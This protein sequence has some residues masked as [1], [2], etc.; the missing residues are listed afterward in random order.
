[1]S[2]PR[3]QERNDDMVEYPGTRFTCP[4]K[5]V[6]CKLTL[7]FTSSLFNSISSSG[8]LLYYVDV[9]GRMLAI[10]VAAFETDAPTGTPS[11][12]PSFSPSSFPSMSSSPTVVSSE[13]PTVFT[14]SP[15]PPPTM[16][17]GMVPSISISIPP[18]TI[19]PIFLDTNAARNQGGGDDD[20]VKDK[21]P[22]ILGV[23][24]GSLLVVAMILFIVGRKRK[25]DEE[26]QEIVVIED[27][28]DDLEGDNE[29]MGDGD[30]DDD[31]SAV[32][33]EVVGGSAVYSPKK[34]KPKKK[35]QQEVSPSGGARSLAAI[36]EVP[37]V[38]DDNTVVVT[39]DEDDDGDSVKNLNDKFA[40]VVEAQTE[41]E[42]TPP[43]SPSRNGAL[44]ILGSTSPKSDYSDAEDIDGRDPLRSKSPSGSSMGSSTIYLDNDDPRTKSVTP[45]PTHL[46]S[47]KDV[48]A[49]DDEA[50]MLLM[51]QPWLDGKEDPPN[52]SR[53]RL[54]RST[55][56]GPVVAPGTH[57]MNKEKLANKDPAPKHTSGRFGTSA[58][59][60]KQPSSAF[61][62]SPKRSNEWKPADSNISSPEKS[63][64]AGPSFKRRSKRSFEG[65]PPNDKPQEAKI[66][67][68]ADAWNDFLKDLEAAEQQFFAPKAR[69]SPLLSYYDSDSETDDV[70]PHPSDGRK[71]LDE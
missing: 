69:P 2:Y 7:S 28:A 48:D 56:D 40:Y 35:K 53:T 58:R 64:S 8:N 63:K 18:T 61:G 47:E 27:I 60:K 31:D 38:N 57:Y 14:A 23:I 19:S 30:G 26:T 11:S 1:M 43:N 16:S 44:T 33:I 10:E 67:K 51:T 15:S 70:P 6:D 25:K 4:L 45:T 34:R 22:V 52:L 66:E 29:S 54:D 3:K 59:Q 39:G 37:E 68:Q 49:P 36:E 5:V 62:S 12:A 24:C 20:S 50:G 13:S 32:A 71:L 65:E 55:E 46:I 42:S 41:A 17:Q 9:S 21:L